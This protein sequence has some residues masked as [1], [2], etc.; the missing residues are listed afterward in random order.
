MCVTLLGVCLNCAYSC[1]SSWLE[2]SY[3]IT[4]WRSCIRTY[5]KQWTS[6]TL[7]TSATSQQS[8]HWLKR[9]DRYMHPLLFACRL[10]S[11][12]KILRFLSACLL[13]HGAAK[14]QNSCEIYKRTPQNIKFK[15]LREKLCII[16]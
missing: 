5:K 1:P 4:S 11:N 7:L 6:T 10:H 15:T 14:I 8:Q 12:I 16:Y 9:P 2:S 13:K 3:S